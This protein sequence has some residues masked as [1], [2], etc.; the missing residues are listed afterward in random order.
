MKREKLT[1]NEVIATIK[2]F[3]NNYENEV[4]KNRRI[5]DSLSIDK[6][7]VLG[8]SILM[9]ISVIKNPFEGKVKRTT[10]FNVI[11]GNNGLDILNYE[12]FDYMFYNYFEETLYQE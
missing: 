4:K 3:A 12:E 5:I 10:R 9:T 8:D 6:D 7:K 11:L 1:Y 2:R